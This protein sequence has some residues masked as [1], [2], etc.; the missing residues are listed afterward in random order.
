MGTKIFLRFGW[1]AAASFSMGLFAWQIGV[2]LLR[3]PHCKRYT[4]VGYEG[5]LESRKRFVEDRTPLEQQE[6]EQGKQGEQEKPKVRGEDKESEAGGE[7]CGTAGT[8]KV[9]VDVV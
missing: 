4:W 1:R 6:M 2:L 3:G 5:G 7:D 9:E 8:T